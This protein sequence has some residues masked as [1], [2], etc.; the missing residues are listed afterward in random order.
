MENVTGP[1]PSH[2][3]VGDLLMSR[4]LISRALA[5]IVTGLKLRQPANRDIESLR[6]VILHVAE[7]VPELIRIFITCEFILQNTPGPSVTTRVQLYKTKL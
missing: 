6:L 4:T 2:V 3:T 1:A 7:K 5:C